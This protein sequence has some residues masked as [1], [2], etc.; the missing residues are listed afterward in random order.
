MSRILLGLNLIAAASICS[1][2]GSAILATISPYGAHAPDRHPAVAAAAVLPVRAASST[3]AA[4]IRLYKTSY[5]CRAKSPA[6]AVTAVA[7]AELP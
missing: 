5:V 1:T 7:V 6:P 4:P 2:Q 3:A